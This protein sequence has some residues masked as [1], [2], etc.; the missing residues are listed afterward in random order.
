MTVLILLLKAEQN[1][2]KV[3]HSKAGDSTQIIERFHGTLKDRTNVVRGFSNMQTARILTDAWLVH[4]NFFKE[5]E[6][7]GNVPPAQ[8]K[9]MPETPIGD[10]VDVID[11]K[12]RTREFVAT[13]I[14]K[15]KPYI[16][17]KRRRNKPR[18]VKEK[19][20]TSSRIVEVRK[21]GV[22]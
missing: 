5:H 10:W 11:G 15:R 6:S 18:E 1:I 17:K 16:R 13:A 21:R 14:P 2:F 20:Y 8:E 12:Q 3:N 19:E 7:L 22:M 9:H 4:Y